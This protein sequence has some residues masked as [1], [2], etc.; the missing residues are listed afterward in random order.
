LNRSPLFFVGKF[1]PPIG[2]VTVFNQRKVAQLIATG[3]SVE[4][5]QPVPKYLLKFINIFFHRQSDLHLSASHFLMICIMLVCGSCSRIIFYDHNSSRHLAAHGYFKKKIHAWF[6]KRVHKVIVV[7]EQLKVNYQI[8]DFYDEII[9]EIESAFLPPS[10]QNIDAIIE[11]YPQALQ[12]I[13][14]ANQRVLVIAS[15]FRP[16]LSAEGQD[17]YSLRQT[18][19]AFSQLSLEY[20]KLFFLISIAQ[21]SDDAFSREIRTQIDGLLASRENVILLDNSRTLWPL[22][23]Q[24]V[25]YIRPTTTDGD[26]ISL[27]E[28]LY[29]GSKVLAS[30][31]VARPSGTVLFNLANDNL[32]DAIRHQLDHLID[33]K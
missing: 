28:A 19:K 7:S 17:I 13:V 20:P 10:E 8:Y 16:N 22:F 21:F 3:K 25:L 4:V 23:K 33:C 6:F 26:A 2:G 30:D 31:I 18:I 12:D 9:F 14:T 29:F 1:P 32:I 11:S 5:I 24:S 27:R 15:A